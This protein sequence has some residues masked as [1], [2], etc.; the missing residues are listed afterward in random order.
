MTKTQTGIFREEHIS[1]MVEHISLYVGRVTP[2]SVSAN[3]E[4][5]TI[6]E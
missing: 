2:I 3:D 6:F 5:T 4:T 1:L